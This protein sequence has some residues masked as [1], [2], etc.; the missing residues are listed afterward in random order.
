MTRG[1]KTGNSA[2]RA[3]MKG[4][5]HRNG[6]G[7]GAPWSNYS[8]EAQPADPSSSGCPLKG[9]G[10]ATPGD[11]PLLRIQE[12][13]CRCRTVHPYRGGSSTRPTR[14]SSSGDTRPSRNAP[15]RTQGGSGWYRNA[16][17]RR[18]GSAL[19]A[20]SITAASA[21][22]C[23]LDGLHS[24]QRGRATQNTRKAL[25]PGLHSATQEVSW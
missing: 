8:P 19:I 16:V 14:P 4:F 9:W 1:E 12:A 10:G 5:S 23:R 25:L 18:P 6:A 7:R 22:R 3:G 11:E 13:R 20:R 17:L 2:V 21:V 15:G 24:N